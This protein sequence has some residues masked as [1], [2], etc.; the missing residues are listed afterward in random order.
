MVVIHFLHAFLRFPCSRFHQLQIL[1]EKRIGL[2]ISRTTTSVSG[3]RG[4]SQLHSSRWARFAFSYFSLKLWSG[5]SIF[6]QTFL[7]FFLTENSEQVIWLT[8]K[9]TQECVKS[10]S[11]CPWGDLL[12]LVWVK[13]LTWNFLCSL[14]PSGWASRH[15]REGPGYDTAV[16]QIKGWPLA[17]IIF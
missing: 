7:I 15:N 9:V 12:W 10:Q 8:N 17:W 13:W 14:W 11:L 4:R 2:I 6:P 1:E 5:L 3:D 16:D